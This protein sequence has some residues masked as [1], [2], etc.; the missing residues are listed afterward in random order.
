MKIVYYDEEIVSTSREILEQ[1]IGERNLCS[2][3]IGRTC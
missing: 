2:E 3:Q 1:F